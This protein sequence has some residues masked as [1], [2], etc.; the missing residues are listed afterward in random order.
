MNCDDIVFI[1]VLLSFL[2]LGASTYIVGLL[3][4]IKNDIIDIKYWRKEVSKD[5][6]SE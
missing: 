4:V 3:T 6:E 5:A 1:L 2:F